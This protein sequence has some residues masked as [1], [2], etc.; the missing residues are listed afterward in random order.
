MPEP[1]PMHR[2][3]EIAPIEDLPEERLASL[4]RARRRLWEA[5]SVPGLE[6][7]AS[8]FAR[9]EDLQQAM[10][11]VQQHPAL[12]KGYARETVRLVEACQQ[13]LGRMR[14]VFDFLEAVLAERAAAA[15]PPPM[16]SLLTTNPGNREAAARRAYAGGAG[17]GRQP[18]LG[19]ARFGGGGWE[20]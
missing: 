13:T 20:G 7:Q 11:A 2:S 3:V 10:Q 9:L 6:G 16:A 15:D 14:Q 4:E 1:R 17:N 5:L 18:G 12:P 19:T 8:L